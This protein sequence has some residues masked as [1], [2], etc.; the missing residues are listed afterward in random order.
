MEKIKLKTR[1]WAKF[2]PT[3][4]WCILI[5]AV[6]IV[7]NIVNGILTAVFGIGILTDAIMDGIIGVMAFLVFEDIRAVGLPTLL[8][9]GLPV[10]FDIIPS[11]TIMYFISKSK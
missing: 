6:D 9:I 3:L 10:G 5:D 8:E 1:K 7:T 11:Y 2:M 4:W